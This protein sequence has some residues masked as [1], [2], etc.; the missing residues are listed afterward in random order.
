VRRSLREYVILYYYYTFSD[1]V[2][3]YYYIDLISEEDAIIVY[4]A[5]RDYIITK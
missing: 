2:I 4:T 3:S 5:S 1:K